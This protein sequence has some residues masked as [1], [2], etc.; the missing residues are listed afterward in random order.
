MVDDCPICARHRGEGPLGGEL[1]DR[2][3]GFWIW[4]AP[5]DADGTTALGHLI[6]DSDRHA[7][8]VDDLTA[9]EAAELGKLRSRLA[10]ALREATGADAVLAAIIGLR[11]AHFHEHLFCRF[12]DTPPEVPW[13][14]SDDAAPR[15]DQL[16][17]VDL[18]RRLR[19]RL[20]P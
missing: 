9:A 16:A 19:D 4:H 18:A 14:Q 17:V 6:I 11:V 5:P 7:P 1:I 10:G 20:K 3:G 2:V 8:H 13:H 15:A 12:A